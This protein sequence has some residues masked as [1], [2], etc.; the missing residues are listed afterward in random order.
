V[1]I[2]CI[3][4]GPA[5]LYF[6]ILMKL[7]DP[8]CEVTVFER[9]KAGSSFGWGVTLEPELMQKL[10]SNDPE[11]AREIA[12]SGFS[13]RKQFIDIRG[14]RIVYESGVDIYNFNRPDLVAI[15][16]ARA[17]RLGVRIEYGHEVLSASELP[18]TD[19]IVAADGVSS[20]L[21][22]KNLNFGTEVRLSSDKY[23]WLGT[24]KVFDTF[25]YHFV[26]TGGGWL[27]ASSYGVGSGLSTFVVHTL[28]ETWRSLGF[29]EMPIRD[30]L[31]VLEELFKDQLEGHR[32]MGQ[33]DDE[34]NA[35][36]LSFRNVTNQRWHDGKVVLAGD[37]AH[38][39]HFSAGQG[40]R[41]AIEDAIA[42]AENLHRGAD[43]EI[44]LESYD[45]QRRAELL[46]TQGQ[47]RR[48]G[49]WFENISRY[50]DLPPREFGVLLHA[51]RSSLLPLLP[52]RLFYQLN[53]ASREV[54]VLRYMRRRAGSLVKALSN[55]RAHDVSSSI[56]A[57]TSASTETSAVTGTK[58]GEQ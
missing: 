29:N 9:N 45:R 10:Y 1:K 2:A 35:R 32:L 4:G 12:Q 23:I 18:D 51:R 22:E 50:V 34:T 54:P 25:A 13:W 53:Q 49:Q 28:P 26:E 16:A 15:L 14:E 5:G 40:T 56:D 33:V 47:A 43:I 3:G 36:W 20:Q 42:L 6:S 19:L 58:T 44:A 41:L 21:R 37:S 46:P 7:A 31:A 55:R 57:R 8:G 11:S 24:D 17:A 48:S 30:S 39:T 38:T 52:P 27:W